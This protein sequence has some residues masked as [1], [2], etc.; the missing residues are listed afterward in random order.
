[1][2]D[3]AL[4]A[5]QHTGSWIHPPIPTLPKNI[6][7]LTG[8]CLYIG[9]KRPTNVSKATTECL[10]S[11]RIATSRVCFLCSVPRCSA[12]IKASLLLCGCPLREDP[13]LCLGLSGSPQKASRKCA[14]QVQAK[15]SKKDQQGQACMRPLASRRVN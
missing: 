5:N 4:Y 12:K 11:R 13:T 2:L 15:Q 8:L 14:K 6:T 7:S 1:M 3:V 9:P 10:K